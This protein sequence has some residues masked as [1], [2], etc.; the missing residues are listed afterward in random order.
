MEKEAE[1]VKERDRK[2]I[3]NDRHITSTVWKTE[4][5]PSKAKANRHRIEE[6]GTLT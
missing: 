3:I 2:A 4:Q 1:T 6:G 5:N